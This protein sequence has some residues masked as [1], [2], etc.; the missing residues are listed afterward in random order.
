MIEELISY[1]TGKA[2]DSYMSVDV[3]EACPFHPDTKLDADLL[4]GGS[5][6]ECRWPKHSAVDCWCG[7][8]WDLR[9][10]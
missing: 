1:H 7:Y 4:E 10:R 9:P 8:S 3:D 5:C 6:P 2:M